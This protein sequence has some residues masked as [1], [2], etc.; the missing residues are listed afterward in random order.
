MA[1]KNEEM[2]S[3]EAQLQDTEQEAPMTPNRDAYSQ[4]WGEDNA[5]IDFEDKE[6]RYGRAIDDRNEL[7]ERRKSDSALGGLFE[8]HDWLATMYME[9]KDNPDINP[10]VWLADFCQEQGISLQEVLDDPEAQKYLTK[11]MADHQKKQAE[12]KKKKADSDAEAKRKDENLQESL[13]A[14]ESVQSEMGLSDEDCLDMWGKFWEMQEKSQQGIVDADTWKAFSKS[15]TY[16]ADMETARN[17]GGMMARNE[18]IQNKVRKP[19][20]DSEGMPPTLSQGMSG[21]SRK[22]PEKKSETSSFLEG[23]NG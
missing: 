13:N 3:P 17:E 1:K 19:S 7:R 10:F 6:A 15:R 18:K 14:L 21:A 8:Q 23:L 11:K 20:E 4:M 16:D 12:A 2:T 22:A 9:L 5:D